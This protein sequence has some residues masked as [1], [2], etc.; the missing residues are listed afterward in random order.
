MTAEKNQSC[1]KKDDDGSSD[2]W[3]PSGAQVLASQNRARSRHHL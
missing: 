2:E 3:P 1:K